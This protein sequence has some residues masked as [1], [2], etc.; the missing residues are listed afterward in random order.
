MSHDTH[1]PGLAPDPPAPAPARPGPSGGAGRGRRPALDRVDATL[2]GAAVLSGLLAGLYY[3]YACSVM[4]G[5][6][7][8]DDHAFVAA[9]QRINEAILNPVFFASFAGAPAMTAA[10]AVVLR[11][12]GDRRP[13]RWALGALGAHAVA[14]LVTS[15]VNV[16]LN[17]ALARDGDRAAFETAWTVANDVRALAATGAL[18]CLAVALASRR[19]A[20]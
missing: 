16:P 19:R 6:R 3:A 18:A 7:R 12:R 10:A 2:T 5:L 4:P 20:A 8:V 14:F 13:A 1:R 9:M 11:R 17:D 15:G